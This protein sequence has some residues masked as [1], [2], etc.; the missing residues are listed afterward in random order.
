MGWVKLTRM[1][2]RKVKEGARGELRTFGLAGVAPVWVQ[3][4]QIAAVTP[5]TAAVY[6]DDWDTVEREVTEL[7]L[8]GNA[9]PLFVAEPVEEVLAALGV[10]KDRAPRRR[11][12]PPA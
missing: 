2:E 11:A 3:P 8:A 1:V 12:T 10:T 7:R 6:T 9:E 4:G 5:W